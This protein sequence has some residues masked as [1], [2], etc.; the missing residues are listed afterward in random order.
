MA[1]SF[2]GLGKVAALL[3]GLGEHQ[4]ERQKRDAEIAL[5]RAQ[6]LNLTETAETTRELRDP[7]VRRETAA[8]GREETD[9]KTLEA[10]YEVMLKNPDKYEEATIAGLR[11]V[12]ATAKQKEAEAETATVV[13]DYEPERQTAALA[14]SEA[15]VDLTLAQTDTEGATQALTEKRREAL[16]LEV[17]FGESTFD[18]RARATKSAAA[19]A[20]IDAD[21]ARKLL[22]DHDEDRE[23]N[24]D[25]IRAKTNLLIAETESISRSDDMAEKTFAHVQAQDAYANALDNRRLELEELRVAIDQDGALNDDQRLEIEKTAA[26]LNNAYQAAVT[27]RLVSETKYPGELGEAKRH[28]DN[29]FREL[30]AG[31]PSAPAYGAVIDQYVFGRGGSGTDPSLKAQRMFGLRAAATNSMFL[32]LVQPAESK[33]KLS[34]VVSI[35]GDQATLTVGKD[36]KYE[37]LEAAFDA[38][39][40]YFNTHGDRLAM[41][42][43]GWGAYTMVDSMNV[44]AMIYQNMLAKNPEKAIKHTGGQQ[45]ANALNVADY[46]DM[47]TADL[48]KDDNLRGETKQSITDLATVKG[49][50][51]GGDPPPP[52]GVE[53]TPTTMFESAME[54]RTG[55]DPETPEPVSLVESIQTPGSP[56][57][58]VEDGAPPE[59]TALDTPVSDQM[60][61]YRRALQAQAYMLGRP[62]VK[63]VSAEFAKWSES[64]ALASGVKGSLGFAGQRFNAR[65]AGFGPGHVVNPQRDF[66]KFTREQREKNGMAEIDVQLAIGTNMS[67][68]DPVIHNLASALRDDYADMEKDGRFITV[69]VSESILET[70][71]IF[72]ANKELFDVALGIE[73]EFRSLTRNSPFGADQGEQ[74]V[75]MIKI[76]L[77]NAIKFQEP[78]PPRAAL[79]EGLTRA[80]LL[81]ATDI[82]SLAHELL[83]GHNAP[84]RSM[85]EKGKGSKLDQAIGEMGAEVAQIWVSDFKQKN[86]QRGGR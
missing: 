9:L 49:V 71:P 54:G 3:A 67:P 58:R 38:M 6:A 43:S 66:R 1:S 37:D 4:N 2:S 82:L 46:S 78:A 36:T 11:T 55:D 42:Q 52:T 27:E 75:E 48:F 61:A 14:E 20:G 5:K 56:T 17:R 65:R 18:D 31:S 81:E 50:G 23:V 8:A 21:M 64:V 40:V 16:D 32:G 83:V 35:T 62:E 86:R 51:A 13:A 15:R 28:I 69:P 22:D 33:G 53:R 30:L 79:K 44:M 10:A 12:I 24:L 26:E 68:T 47:W 84:L 59:D 29:Y 60:K 7:K 25:A 74:A 39:R 63:A 80:Q 73:K 19:L 41:A 77:I 85:L 76:A 34:K 72:G 57:A 70:Y 45:I